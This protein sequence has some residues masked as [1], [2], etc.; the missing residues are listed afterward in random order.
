MSARGL[1]ALVAALALALVVVACGGGES[2]GSGGDSESAAKLLQ[3]ASK[4]PAKSAD[5][6]FSLEADLKGVAQLDGPVKLSFEG[7]YRSNGK[8][9]M[10][11]LDWKVRGAA[12]G[13]S[14]EARAITLR[15]NA[16][17][18]YQGTTYEVGRELVA[19]LNQQ[20]KSGR[21]GQQQ[22]SALGLDTS[23]WI[24]DA[25]V[26]DGEAGG[27]PTKH[28][29]GDVD[30]RKL[31]EGLNKLFQSPS[32]TG[33]LPPGAATPKLSRQTI[34]E[35]AAAVKD[36]GVEADVGRDD[37]I[38]RRS[39]TDISFDVPEKR[40][41]E[42]KGLEGGTVKFS[43]EQ[44]DVNGDQKVTAPSGARPIAELLRRIGIP[45]EMLLG[46]GFSTPSPG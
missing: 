6:K 9:A 39:A 27:V 45:P 35:V 18:Q 38:M 26:E 3:Q 40:R 16:Y 30:V 8:G 31:L 34:D 32:V 42:L 13:T 28:I 23:K 37:G 20:L 10:P 12:A 17:V 21:A 14:I 46:P 7:P 19:K 25:K 11:D 5:V 44:S 29:T 22:L 4:K 41:A 33:Q 24:R 36:A 43:F 2:G 15:D 1:I